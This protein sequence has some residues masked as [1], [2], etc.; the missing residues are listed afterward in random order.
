MD[1]D[2]ITFTSYFVAKIS[3]PHF[4]VKK[5]MQT[6]Y[7]KKWTAC[8]LATALYRTPNRNFHTMIVQVSTLNNSFG[9]P[10]AVAS[11]RRYPNEHEHQ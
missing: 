1:D 11:G 4:G 2:A 3:G 9:S 5:W 6:Y 10:V 8:S 7:T